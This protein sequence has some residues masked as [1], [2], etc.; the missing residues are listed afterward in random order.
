MTVSHLK[1]EI[2]RLISEYNLEDKVVRV[3]VET[4]KKK[5]LTKIT[6]GMI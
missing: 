5:C 3:I 1:N 2:E 6:A 4:D